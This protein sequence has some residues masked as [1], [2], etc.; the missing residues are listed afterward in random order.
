MI[1]PAGGARV[2]IVAGVTDLHRA[3]AGLN[4]QVQTTLEEGP[5][6]GHVFVRRGRRGDLVRLLW[7]D[8]D[9][10]CLLAKRVERGRFIWPRAKNGVVVLMRAHLSMMLEGIDWRQPERTDAP[11]VGV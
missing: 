1:G 6:S 7:W 10:L 2:W 8:G 4:A 9:G 5:F 3:F 11:R